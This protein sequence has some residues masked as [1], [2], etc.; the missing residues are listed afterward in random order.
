MSFNIYLIGDD[1]V[2]HNNDFEEEV[3][4]PECNKRAKAVT[5]STC[6]CDLDFCMGQRCGGETVSYYECSSCGWKGFPKPQN[7]SSP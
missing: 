4:C 2:F 1:V 6:I 5:R 3:I 7:N